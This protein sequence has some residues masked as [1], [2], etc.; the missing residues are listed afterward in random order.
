MV[1][2]TEPRIPGCVESL[3][4]VC[5][6]PEVGYAQVG[7]WERLFVRRPLTDA[8]ISRYQ[9][10]GRYG[11]AVLKATGVAALGRLVWSA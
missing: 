5:M 1:L 6:D 7:W 8:A 4:G 9:R 3:P 11:R 10:A 2:K